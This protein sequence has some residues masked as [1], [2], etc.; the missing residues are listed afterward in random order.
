[1]VQKLPSSNPVTTLLDFAKIS[2]YVNYWATL[3]EVTLTDLEATHQVNKDDPNSNWGAVN[4]VKFRVW[5]WSDTPT[6]RQ[7]LTHLCVR[8][9]AKDGYP[10][11]IA[12]A[13]TAITGWIAD[14]L[15]ERPL[16]QDGNS[17]FAWPKL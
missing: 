4:G 13:K 14:Y 17:I 9:A 6:N 10:I 2:E 3:N 5:I 16:S 7:M 12:Q 8:D 11:S 1:M 15:R